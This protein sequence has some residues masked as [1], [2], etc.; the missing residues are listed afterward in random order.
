MRGRERLGNGSRSRGKRSWTL[1]AT[2]LLGGLLLTAA[3]RLQAVEVNQASQAELER[4]R[5][6]GP[7]M[8]EQLIEQRTQRPFSDWDDLRRRVRGLGPASMRRLSAEGLTIGGR[9]LDDGPQRGAAESASSAP[10]S[11]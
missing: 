8:S 7:A 1:S 2:R 5:G 6:I 10:A 4:L 9:R 11:R 3:A